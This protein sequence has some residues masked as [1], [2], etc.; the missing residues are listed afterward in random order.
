MT[1]K[2]KLGIAAA[3]VTL[4]VTIVVAVL[5]RR[6]TAMALTFQGY[7]SNERGR[8]TVN[9]LIANAGARGLTVRIG[10]HGSA[11]LDVTRAH[12]VSLPPGEFQVLRLPMPRKGARR[13]TALCCPTLPLTRVERARAYFKALMRKEVSCD[14]HS[15]EIPPPPPPKRPLSRPPYPKEASPHGMTSRARKLI[16]TTSLVALAVTVAL[17]WPKPK[18]YTYQGKTV[19]ELFR[20][21][22]CSVKNSP[23]ERASIARAFRAMG[24]DAALFSWPVGSIG[25]PSCHYWSGGHSNGGHPRCR[26]HERHSNTWLKPDAPPIC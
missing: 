2:R 10:A 21:Y 4:A 6:P 26:W 1:L 7:G 17:C 14:V 24:T 12:R 9:I 19:Q 13:V 5:L 25:A 16:I 23:H 15:L 18:V 11:P 22:V 3:L 8:L 20:E